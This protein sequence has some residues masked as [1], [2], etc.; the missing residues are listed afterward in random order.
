MSKTNKTI[1][2]AQHPPD[3]WFDE[4]E[5]NENDNPWQILYPWEDG[6]YIEI[7]PY[8]WFVDGDSWVMDLSVWGRESALSSSDL[9]SISVVPNPYFIES[10]YN[11]SPGEHRLHFTKLPNKCTISIYTVSGEFVHSI[12]HNDLFRGDEFWDLKNGQGKLVAPGLY[13]YVVEASGIEPHIGKFA[14]IR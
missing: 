1:D 6:D 2:Q 4:N 12:N 7:H 13:L 10:D 11:E 5:D 9:D 14:V 8:K 3:I